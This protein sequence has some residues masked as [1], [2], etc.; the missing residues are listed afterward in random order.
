MN[1]KLPNI[2]FGTG[3]SSAKGKEELLKLCLCA[4]ESNITAFDT[5]PSYKTEKV[6]GAILSEIQK[7]KGMSREDIYIQ[8]KIDPNQM[9]SGK[10]KIKIHVETVMNEMNIDYL[11]G[12]LIHWPL[13]EYIDETW[14]TILFLKKKGIVK[15]IGVCNVRLR[16]LKTMSGTKKPDIIQ[17]ER[18]PLRTCNE[19]MEFCNKEGINVQSYSPLCKMHHDLKNSELLNDLAYKYAREIGEIILRWHVQTN[20]SPIFTS[21]NMSRIKKYSD[22]FTFELDYEDVR[23]ITDMNKNYKMYLESWSCPGF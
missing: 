6:L 7:I 4:V 3:L 18:N 19:E 14:D 22:I 5:A 15:N 1:D 10:E 2:H 13:P 9:I 21:K 11:D 8:T 20:S 16:Q 17:I 12:L 23:K